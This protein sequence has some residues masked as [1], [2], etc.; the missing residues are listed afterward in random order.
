MAT[1]IRAILPAI[2]V[3]VA[4]LVRPD[5]PEPSWS[6]SARYVAGHIPGARLVELPG[7]DGP[8]WIGNLEALT[9]AVDRFIDNIREER[10]ELDRV[11]ATVL[12]TDIVGSTETATRLG[13]REWHELL[14]RHNATVR[15][16]LDRFRGTEVDTAGD[17]FFATF[18]GPARAIRCALAIV[19]S[20]GS[21][22]IDVR[23]GVHTGECESID[24]KLGGI[25][26][27][28]G[29]RVAA[30]AAPREVLVSQTV[31]DLVAG[32]GLTFDDRGEH[33]LKGVP[34]AWRLYRA[35]R[36]PTPDQ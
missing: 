31:R 17:G 7:R 1:D 33:V 15:A 26:V 12:F 4:V 28:I 18:D 24:G 11:V 30:E 21:L 23:A 35:G 13:D 14:D 6:H 27:N 25:A 36:P 32:S 5:H 29:A 34:D 2:R 10:G 20:L 8:L 19:E 16:L 3:P 9:R 22:G